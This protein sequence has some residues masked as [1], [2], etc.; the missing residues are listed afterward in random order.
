MKP[1]LLFGRPGAADEI[2]ALTKAQV[3][4]YTRS[5]GTY[6]KPHTTSRPA[7][8]PKA[9]AS[10]RGGAKAKAAPVVRSNNEGYGFF[11]SAYDSYRRETYGDDQY[12]PNGKGGEANDAVAR[13]FSRVANELVDAGHFDNH[14]HARDYLDS[15]HG[16]HLGDEIGHK[17]SIHDVKWL[18]KSVQKFKS[19]EGIK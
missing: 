12:V 9:S 15:S 10:K 13:S 19:A 2:E 3:K 5:D 14:D 17:G 1:V 18:P 4:G 7:A 8:K 16:R 11:G 6:V